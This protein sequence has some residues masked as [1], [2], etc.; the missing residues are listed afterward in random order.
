MIRYLHSHNLVEF[1]PRRAPVAEVLPD[2]K[3]SPSPSN[4]LPWPGGIPIGGPWTMNPYWLGETVF[5]VASGPSIKRVNFELIR[6]RKIICIN[7]SFELVPFASIVYF[8]DGRWYNEHKVALNEF[9]GHRVTCSGLVK[10]KIVLRVNRFKPADGVGFHEHRDGLASQRT[11]LQGGM[12]MAAHLNS[13]DKIKGKIVLI[14]ADM[15]RDPVTGESHGHKPH[16]WPSRAGNITWDEQMRHL[17]WIVKPLQD[18]GIEVFNTSLGSRIPW[19]PK[20]SLEEFLK[21]EA[22]K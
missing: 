14:G 16:R 5:V 12:N 11:S 2:V 18:R 17:K 19:W 13:N 10:S 9:K 8:G 21:K 4:V 6:G 22:R 20:I 1:K 3:V 15:G 7:S